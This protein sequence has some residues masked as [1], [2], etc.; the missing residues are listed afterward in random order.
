MDPKTIAEA[1]FTLGTHIEDSQA[2]VSDA[3]EALIPLVRRG[4][5]NAVQALG[6]L[7]K[8]AVSMQ[9]ERQWA[10]YL[11]QLASG[12]NPPPPAAAPTTTAAPT[13]DDTASPRTFLDNLLGD[14]IT[15]LP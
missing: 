12:K 8:A 14:L 10:E 6:N 2:R 3:A 1:Y 9:A 15:L 7:R 4:D 11:W 5:Q 13:P